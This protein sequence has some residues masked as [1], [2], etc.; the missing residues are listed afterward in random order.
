[1]KKMITHETL[2]EEL[3]SRISL[4]GERGSVTGFMQSQQSWTDIESKA[5]RTVTVR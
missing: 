1:M 2:K 3:T 4:Q 5:V